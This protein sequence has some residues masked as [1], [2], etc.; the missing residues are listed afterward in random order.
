VVPKDIVK[1]LRIYYNNS[2]IK[3]IKI[4]IIVLILKQ[5]FLSN[6]TS[7]DKKNLNQTKLILLYN[8]LYYFWSRY[9]SLC[10][11]KNKGKPLI[12]MMLNIFDII[13]FV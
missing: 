7:I 13:K 12:K 9:Y 10:M 11:N 1:C 5:K 4:G 6:L 3:C 8:Y 2:W